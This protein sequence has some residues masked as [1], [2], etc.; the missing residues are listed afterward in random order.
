MTQIKIC[1]LSRPCD[2]EFVN[3]YRPDY[4][5]FIINYP[6]SRRNVSPEWVRR[7]T[8]H[9]DRAV[10]PVGVFV[11]QELELVAGLLHSGAVAVAQLHGHEDEG[12]LA[13]LRDLAPEAELWKAFKVRSEEDLDRARASSAHRILLD[14]GYGTGKTF[15]WTL[16]TDLGRP[17]ILA[18]GLTPEN[19][20][21]AIRAMGPDCVDI[22]SGVETD[23][24]KDPQKI[25]AAIA[26]VRS[27]EA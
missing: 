27:C 25:R 17:F 24:L 11:D 12:Y 6:R 8:A 21:G 9:L 14:N 4:C 2:I 16:V 1:G 13:R 7:L 3:Q 15:D 10:T 18:G 23:G 20:P 19:L 26:A 5:G 22:S